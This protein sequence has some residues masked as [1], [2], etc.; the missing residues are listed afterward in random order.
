MPKHTLL[1]LGFS[2]PWIGSFR[3]L[4]LAAMVVRTERSGIGVLFDPADAAAREQVRA[5]LRLQA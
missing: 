2:I 3:F 4:R 5:L 1:E